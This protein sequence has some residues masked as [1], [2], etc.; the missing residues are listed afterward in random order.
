MPNFVYI[1]LLDQFS[2]LNLILSVFFLSRLDPE[3]LAA[4]L[5]RKY[6]DI[7]DGHPVLY[8]FT[9]KS[10]RRLNAEAWIAI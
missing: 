4:L 5:G 8:D 7:M 6:V 10:V 2:F 9:H 1:F 3:T